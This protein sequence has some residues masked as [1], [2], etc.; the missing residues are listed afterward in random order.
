MARIKKEIISKI[1]GSLGDLTFHQRYGKSDVFTCLFVLL[2]I[3]I[4]ALKNIFSFISILLRAPPIV[5][6]DCDCYIF[7]V[8]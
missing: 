3:E 5:F 8:K 1:S 2:I 6:L 4:I 7:K